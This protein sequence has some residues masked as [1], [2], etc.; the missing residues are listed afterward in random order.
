[1]SHNTDSSKLFFNK[2]V[3]NIYNAYN[4]LFINP[5]IPKINN[6]LYE[7]VNIFAS[8]KEVNPSIKSKLRLWIIR[9][10]HISFKVLSH[11]PHLI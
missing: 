9:M 2:E 10:K 8:K 11:F 4:T 3:E 6:L 5:N 1:M 7:V